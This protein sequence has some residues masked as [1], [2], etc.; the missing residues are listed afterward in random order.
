VVLHRDTRNVPIHFTAFTFTAPRTAE[1]YVNQLT[2][3]SMERM[4]QRQ[5]NKYVAHLTDAKHERPCY[6]TKSMRR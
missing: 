4:Y 1:Y 2:A 5:R 3:A 6:T